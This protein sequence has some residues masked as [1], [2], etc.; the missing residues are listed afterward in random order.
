MVGGGVP[1]Y[2]TTVC[3][4]LLINNRVTVTPS[5]PRGR[6][7]TVPRDNARPLSDS[8][9][10]G[11]AVTRSRGDSPRGP[12]GPGARADRRQRGARG[13]S[14]SDPIRTDYRSTRLVRPR[15]GGPLRRRGGSR[16]GGDGHCD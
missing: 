6:S 3:H 8:G 14:E 7:V 16:P 1:L 4:D 13:G 11:R 12:P 10:S 15:Y 5:D 2:Q 9:P